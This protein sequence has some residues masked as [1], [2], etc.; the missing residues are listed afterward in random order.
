MTMFVFIATAILT[1]GCE[2]EVTA[3]NYYDEK[4]NAQENVSIALR[5]AKAENKRVL[6]VYGGNWCGWCTRLHAVLKENPDVSAVMAKH[7]VFVPIAIDTGKA[8][9]DS[10]QTPVDGV[11]VI[12][13]LDADGKKLT[14]Q[15]PGDFTK[16]ADYAPNEV[17]AFLN[18][19]SHGA[20]PPAADPTANRNDAP[21]GAVSAS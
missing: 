8:V 9:A 4:A 17:L 15:E 19:W 3:H 10:Y 14:D 21:T 6:L 16:G 11:P 5:Q 18:R 1:G 12:S 20:P 13:I 2:K 7:F